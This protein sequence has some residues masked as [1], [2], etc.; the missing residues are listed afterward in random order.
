M[1]GIEDL[2]GYICPQPSPRQ[3]QQRPKTPQTP[4]YDEQPSQD[5]RAWHVVPA[6]DDFHRPN[7]AV[8]LW[9]GKA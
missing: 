1:E 2:L 7:R 5:G 9:K 4:R 3:H 8:L 6:S